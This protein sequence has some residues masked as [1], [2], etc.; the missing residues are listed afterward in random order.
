MKDP[1]QNF[2]EFVKT[3]LGTVLVFV[4]LF[5]IITFAVYYFYSPGPEERKQAEQEIQNRMLSQQMQNV[6]NDT[7]QQETSGTQA[8]NVQ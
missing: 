1:K 5:Y 3:P 4:L 6:V 7:T 2:Q 8:L